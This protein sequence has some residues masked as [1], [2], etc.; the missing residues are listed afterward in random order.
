MKSLLKCDV[1]SKVKVNY[2]AY[3]NLSVPIPNANTL[4]L[5]VVVYQIPSELASILRK[6]CNLSENDDDIQ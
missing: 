4:L 1:C 3:S 2:Q 5:S 6:A